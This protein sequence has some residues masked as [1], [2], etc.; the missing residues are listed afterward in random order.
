MTDATIPLPEP[1]AWTSSRNGGKTWITTDGDPTELM[2]DKG[3]IVHSLHTDNQ[4]RAYAAAQSAADNA[5]L[6]AELLR[7]NADHRETIEDAA[8]VVRENAALTA[9]VKALED[10]LRGVVS[11][12]EGLPTF[13]R[14]HIEQW[15]AQPLKAARAALEQKP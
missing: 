13:G 1:I 10:A 5:A 11:S 4:L 6:R 7:E 2:P 12:I 15:L 9:R 14:C 3:G 8:A